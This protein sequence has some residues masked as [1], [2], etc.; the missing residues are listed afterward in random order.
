MRIGVVSDTHMPSR[1]K[2]LPAAL[3]AGLKG[4]D[5]I[6]HA[7]DFTSPDVIAMLEE[8]APLD[9]VMGNND[10]EDIYRRFDRRKVL[11]LAGYRIGLIHGDGYGRTTEE[12]ARAAFSEDPPDVIIFGHSH[13]PYKAFDQGVLMFNPGSPTDKR[14]QPAFSYGI[15]ELGDTL[16]AEHYFYT[17]KS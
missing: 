4:V 16:T 12:R 1:A 6:L 3:V 8:L 13:V 11:E 9:A 10:G 7:G 17:D 2:G 15:L 14:R 5:R